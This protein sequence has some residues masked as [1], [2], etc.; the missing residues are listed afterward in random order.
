[1]LDTRIAINTVEPIFPA[2]PISYTR[3]AAYC[4]GSDVWR[5]CVANTLLTGMSPPPLYLHALSN[6]LHIF[7]H[8][9][10]SVFTAV[11]VFSRLHARCR[12]QAVFVEVGLF[13]A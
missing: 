13:Q 2:R 6:L 11:S 10:V 3:A 4:G 12:V 8:T 9:T 7:S 5:A 1:M